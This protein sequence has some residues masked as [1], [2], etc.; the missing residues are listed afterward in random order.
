VDSLDCGT[1]YKL[2]TAITTDRPNHKI[3]GQH[4]VNSCAVVNV[5]TLP[6]VSPRRHGVYIF[7]ALFGL[8]WFCV[9]LVTFCEK[10]RL[11]SLTNLISYL[12]IYQVSCRKKSKLTV[13]MNYNIGNL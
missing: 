12:F 8:K 6:L 4:A 9:P 10:L 5:C 7:V 13:C 11:F 2:L 1:R 3:I